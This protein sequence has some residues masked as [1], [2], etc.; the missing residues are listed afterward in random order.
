MTHAEHLDNRLKGIGIDT[1]SFK[2]IPMTPTLPRASSPTQFR[3][4]SP[5]RSRSVTPTITNLNAPSTTSLKS[6]ETMDSPWNNT[7]QSND[8]VGNSSPVLNDSSMVS[9]TRAHPQTGLNVTNVQANNLSPFG[10]WENDDEVLECRSCRK[11]FGLWIRRHHCRRCGRVVC[12]KCSTARVDLPPDQVITDPSQNGEPSQSGFHRVC[13]SCY[14]SM[15]LTARPRP[16]SFT[17]TTI[18]SGS[19]STNH[20]RRLSNNSTMTECPVCNMSLSKV[21]GNQEEHVKKCFENENGSN[22]VGYKYVGER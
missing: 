4:E 15:G 8:A 11:K 2:E 21:A 16:S 17:S 18:V 9:P 3:F 20:R 6:F 7:V 12:D 19:S 1:E 10:K 13:D 5:I 22:V 14:T